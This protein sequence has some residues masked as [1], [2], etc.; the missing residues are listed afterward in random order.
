MNESN[1]KLV[2]Q[3]IETALANITIANGYN[4]DMGTNV[5][6][7]KISNTSDQMPCVFL[8]D[9]DAANKDNDEVPNVKG[10]ARTLNIKVRKRIIIEAHVACDPNRPN[11][12]GHDAL[13]DIKALMMD[14]DRSFDG[15]S[16]S[17]LWISDTFGRREDGVAVIP[18]LSQF[19]ITYCL[20]FVP[21]P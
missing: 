15:I 6:W 2:M 1:D 19:D 20:D 21:K 13:N 11:A 12:A 8:I 7:G 18:V 17:T 4:T 10:R 5:V 14:G 16:M 3:N 9:G